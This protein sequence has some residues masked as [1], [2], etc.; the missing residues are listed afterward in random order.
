LVDYPG[1][2]FSEQVLYYRL[3][4]AYKL[5]INSFEDLIPERLRVAQEYYEAFNNRSKTQELKK[6]AQAFNI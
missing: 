5:A 1:S 4:S 6:K 3:E 2:K